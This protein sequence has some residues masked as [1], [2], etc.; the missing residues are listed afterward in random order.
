MLE[1]HALGR[2]VSR[3]FAFSGD[4]RYSTVMTRTKFWLSGG[5]LLLALGAAACSDVTN[6]PT[7]VGPG[8]GLPLYCPNAADAYAVANALPLPFPCTMYANGTCMNPTPYDPS[9]PP[10]LNYHPCLDANRGITRRNG[11]VC[12]VCTYD[13]QDF[14]AV[15]LA[16]GVCTQ[17]TGR[18]PYQPTDPLGN[19]FASVIC[20][21]SQ[22]DG[23]PDN[24]VPARWGCQ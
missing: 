18:S 16:G 8:G 11:V 12:Y 5:L 23:Q 17:D 2:R 22:A 10:P 15:N 24:C 7:S 3:R 21:P 1:A 9:L 14:Y 6:P 20:V 4:D 19:P 13:T